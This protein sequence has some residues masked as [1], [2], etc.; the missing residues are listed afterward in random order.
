MSVVPNKNHALDCLH[1][2]YRKL[3]MF[4][5]L[6]PVALQHFDSI[7]STIQLPRRA[8][9]F[10]E[11]DAANSVFVLCSGKV[12]LFCT[13]KEG[14]VL[15]LKIAGPGDVLGLS[16]VLSNTGYEITAE[17]MELC[18][19]K[20]IQRKD[21]L[22]FI[23][24]YAEG[25]M[26]TVNSLSEEYKS[27]FKNARRLV[28]SG[29]TS[30]RLARLLLDWG[31]ASDCGKPQLRFTMSLTHEELASMAGTTRETISRLLS[32]FQ[33]E[34]LIEVHGSSMTILNPAHLEGMC[35]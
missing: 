34:N 30:G 19:T 32:R 31:I 17:V 16:A 10:H 20:V 7:G 33:R 12:K 24:L 28:L 22:K 27:A 2:E 6:S 14:K 4:C 25:S 13:S 11:G 18:Q 15:T 21:F 8:V 5:N 35:S 23:D 9:L 1:C 29:S 26:H 3:R